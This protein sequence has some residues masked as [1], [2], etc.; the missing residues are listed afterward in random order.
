MKKLTILLLSFV[1]A[2]TLC[3]Q[4]LQF[5]TGKR[6]FL[7]I[8]ILME[9]GS[10]KKG[11]AQD[12]MLPDVATFQFIGGN[13]EKS[14]HLDRKEVKFKSSKEDKDIQLIPVS[15]IK[16]L[17]YTN[18]DTNEVFQLDK[19]IVKEINNDLEMES[20]GRVLMLPLM[21]KGPIN[22][23]GYRSMMCKANYGNNFATGFDG[24]EDNCQLT[25]VMIYLSKP[26]ETV[27]VAPVDYSSLSP[28]ALFNMKT[29]YKKFYK[30]YEI[31]G[32]DCPEFLKKVDEARKNEYFS[33]KTFKENRKESDVERK[34]MVKGKKGA[35]AARINMHY[36]TELYTKMYKKL[37]D[38]YKQSCP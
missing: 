32:A 38:D 2:S 21:E 26:G 15:D 23:Y 10:T 7:P 37:L 14:A 30:A 1:T 24:N 27:A 25:Y 18:E 6:D 20:E 12:F 34:A 13:S 35:E 33:N 22:L 28:L 8:E 16:S 9:D 31:V 19:R 17:I 36:K 29:L 4:S 5:Y 11:V 3:A